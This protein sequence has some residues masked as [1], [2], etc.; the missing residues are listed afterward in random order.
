VGIEVKY[1][2]PGFTRRTFYAP[3][4]WPRP[5]QTHIQAAHPHR[6]RIEDGHMIVLYMIGHYFMEA[7]KAC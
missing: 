1:Y 5:G 4:R 2:H 7:E 3:S 6:G